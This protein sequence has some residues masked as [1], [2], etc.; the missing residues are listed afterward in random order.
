MSYDRALDLLDP[1]DV[2]GKGQV[3]DLP[4]P[5]NACGD[6]PVDNAFASGWSVTF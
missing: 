3:V 5:L 1:G 6:T 4:D 2:F